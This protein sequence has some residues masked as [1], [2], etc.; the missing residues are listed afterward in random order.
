MLPIKIN[1]QRYDCEEEF[2]FIR[3]DSIDSTNGEVL[4]LA[5]SHQ[6]ENEAARRVLI[7]KIYGREVFSNSLQKHLDKLEDCSQVQQMLYVMG[8]KIVELEKKL[9]GK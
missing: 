9:E 3:V 1:I 4:Y 2:E 6:T 8:K 7:L 5:D